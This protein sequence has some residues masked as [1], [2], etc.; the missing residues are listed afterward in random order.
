M[1]FALISM[2][3]MLV[4][5]SHASSARAEQR[6]SPPSLLESGVH[7]L[8]PRTVYL[9]VSATSWRTRGRVSFP[10]EPAI[11]RKLEAAGFV[12][13]E[14][15]DDGYDVRVKVEYRET[16]GRP[17]ST[18][19]S[20]TDLSCAV[21]LEDAQGGQL[22]RLVIVESPAYA[23]LI[24]APYVDAVLALE[25]NPYFYFL[26]D[27]LRGIA[28]LNMDAT[29]AL[30]AAMERWIDH[31][32]PGNPAGADGVTNPADTLPP[33]ETL[34]QP[35][36]LERTAEELGRLGDVRA[37]PV[38]MRAAQHRDPRLRTRAMTALG[39]LQHPEVRLVLEH[40]VTSDPD[41]DVREAAT[42]ALS[43]TT[44]R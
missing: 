14:N 9:T 25:T 38:L 18:T 23:G 35:K 41:S 22:A 34:Q 40:A 6:T 3:V 2:L 36:A 12:V 7:Q 11:R 5:W 31:T 26:G 15:R 1:R 19:L 37:A 16:E 27:V 39:R 42:A 29:G 33:S 28:L 17:I 13:T 20:G 44:T 8:A 43:T 4:G 24:T 10:I 30:I 32:D 21:T